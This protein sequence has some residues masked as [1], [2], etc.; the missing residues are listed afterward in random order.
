MDVDTDSDHRGTARAVSAALAGL[1]GLIAVRSA[2]PAGT[3][4]IRL[5][6]KADS[7]TAERTL[8]DDSQRGG[9]G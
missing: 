7:A 8:G 6:G 4:R 5:G 1:G 3:P 9:P 2:L